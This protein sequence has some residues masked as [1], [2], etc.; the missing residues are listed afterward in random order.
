MESSCPSARL[1]P[2]PFFFEVLVGLAVGGDAADFVNSAA[3][4]H[5]FA[6]FIFLAGAFRPEA[7]VPV[8]APSVES[9]AAEMDFDPAPGVKVLRSKEEL[10]PATGDPHLLTACNEESNNTRASGEAGPDFP[11]EDCLPVDTDPGLPEIH[12]TEETL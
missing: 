5:A 11:K 6:T 3:F 12:T 4:T 7:E 10:G 9:R 8:Q 1:Y 2:P